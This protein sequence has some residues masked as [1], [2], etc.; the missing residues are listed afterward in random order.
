MFLRAAV[1]N[2]RELGSLKQQKLILPQLQK[3]EVLTQGTSRHKV[4]W[5]SLFL[6]SPSFQ[7]LRTFRDCGC[8]TPISAS[9]FTQPLPLWHGSF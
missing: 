6:V 3:P 5:E 7:G 4:L 2:D 1:T 9:V 8:L